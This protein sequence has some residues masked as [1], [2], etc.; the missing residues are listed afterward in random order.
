MARGAVVLTDGIEA[1]FP[2]DAQ[3]PRILAARVE[4]AT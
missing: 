3:L 1:R 4:G 2:V